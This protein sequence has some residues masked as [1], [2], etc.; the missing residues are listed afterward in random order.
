MLEALSQ[1]SRCHQGWFLVRLL[2]LGCREL[3][4]LC[5]PMQLL[6]CVWCGERENSGVF[7]FLIRI[8]ILF[9][10]SP[11]LMTSL[12]LIILKT[13]S[14]NKATLGVRASVYEFSGGRGEGKDT[15]QFITPSPPAPYSLF[16]VSAVHSSQEPSSHFCWFLMSKSNLS[17]L[18]P[19]LQTSGITLIQAISM[20]C[21][22]GNM[23]VEAETEAVPLTKEGAAL[24]VPRL[25][26]PWV[27][28]V[29]L[30]L[31]VY[32]LK[33]QQAQLK[34]VLCLFL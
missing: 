4:S 5:V 20:S 2:F 22:S 9:D 26:C 8:P 1:R 7:L 12:N 34:Y 23:V 21:D 13:F 19:A 16:P 17:H 28:F 24:Y 3:P 31:C 6:P 25:G 14:A 27:S 15:I 30:N 32:S 11:T 29:S 18:A 10:W 33:N